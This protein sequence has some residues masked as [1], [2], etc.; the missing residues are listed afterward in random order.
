MTK[1]FDEL[2]KKL[3]SQYGKSEIDDGLDVEKE[4]KDVVDDRK[5][6][7]Y[8]KIVN[9]HEKEIPKE[10]YKGLKKMENSYKKKSKKL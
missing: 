8:L 9:A 1:K 2:Y 5:P 3:T 7:E 6:E 4:H 10:Y